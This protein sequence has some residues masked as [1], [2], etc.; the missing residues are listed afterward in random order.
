LAQH[1]G[2]RAA[3]DVLRRRGVADAVESTSYSRI[4]ERVIAAASDDDG[5]VGL[6]PDTAAALFE[7]AADAVVAGDLDTLRQLLDEHPHL[8]RA[9][10]P[11]PHRAT[12]LIYCGANGVEEFRQRTPP[13]AAAIAELL[14]TRGADANAACRLYGGGSTTMG[15]LTTS[16][17]PREAGVD[18]DLIRVLARFGVAL[19]PRDLDHAIDSGAA[20]AAAA[21]AAAGVPIETLFA[22]AG[23]D[24]LDVMADLVSRGADVNARWTPWSSTALHAAAAMDRAA[25]ARFLLEHGADRSLENIWGATPAGAARYFGHAGIAALIDT[26]PA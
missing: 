16:I 26:F 13:N 2:H 19:S 7:R 24:R 6:T 22:A 17:H 23:L 1:Y 10:S 14:L 15:L 4:A 3:A 5:E 12:L 8:A 11:R 21:I 20:R 18:G 25:A 9:R